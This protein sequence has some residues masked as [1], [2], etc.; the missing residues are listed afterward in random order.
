MAA[1]S[2]AMGTPFERAHRAVA[3][4][5][6]DAALHTQTRALATRAKT[7]AAAVRI[8]QADYDKWKRQAL[9]KHGSIAAVPAGSRLATHIARAQEHLDHRKAAHTAAEAAVDEHGSTSRMVELGIDP[10]AGRAAIEK[11]IQTDARERRLRG[12]QESGLFSG[13][14]GVWLS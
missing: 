8:A 9:D 6:Y 5:H 3:S 14:A 10:T 1:L 12:A 2:S 13:V 7:T 4:P 11:M